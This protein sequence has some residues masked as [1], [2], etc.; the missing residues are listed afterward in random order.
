MSEGQSTPEGGMGGAARPVNPDGT[1]NWAIVFND[2]ERG[3]LAAVQAVTSTAQLCAVME[4]V[5][6]LLFKRRHDEAPRAAF[7]DR[8]AAIVEANNL[9]LES[10]RTDVLNL[11]MAERDDRIAK[12]EQYARNKDAGQGIE[13]RREKARSG[14][15]SGPLRIG[16]LLAAVAVVGVL[17]ILLLAR[18]WDDLSMRFSAEEAPVYN[19]APSKEKKPEKEKEAQEATPAPPP[20]IKDD[21]TLITM[22]AMKPLALSVVL[23]GQVRR[24]AYIPLIAIGKDDKIEDICALSPWLMEGVTL[25]VHAL[26]EQ[27]IEATPDAMNRIATKVRSDINAR[28]GAEM[29]L[30][31]LVNTRDLPRSTVNAAHNGCV[32]VQFDHRP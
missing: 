21:E 27:K 23:S 13:R 19:K 25:Q 1:T 26:T 15:F 11:L 28:G 30:L 17:A 3:V 12:A 8:I 16:L 4:S 18:S 14:I 5:A 24:Q 20:V 31:R 22:L 29:P 2:P 6:V 7:L 32:R 10:T 9:D